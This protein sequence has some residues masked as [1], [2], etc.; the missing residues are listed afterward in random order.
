MRGAEAR[1]LGALAGRLAGDMTSRVEE[2]HLA[3]ADRS[4]GNAGPGARPARVIHDSIAS[5]IYGGAARAPAAPPPA[6]QGAAAA[7]RSR[8]DAPALGDFA[9]RMVSRWRR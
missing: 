4:F 7:V 1:S 3:I 8:P 5:A 9:A 2:F 6:R